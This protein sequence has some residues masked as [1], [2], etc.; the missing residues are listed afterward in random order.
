MMDR[1][2]GRKEPHIV[3]QTSAFGGASLALSLNFPSK[4]RVDTHF[5]SGIG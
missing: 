2:S 4:I 5:S 1:P 3:R